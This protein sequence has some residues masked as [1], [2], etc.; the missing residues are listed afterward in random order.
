[1]LVVFLIYLVGGSIID[2]MAFVIL[3]TP[4]FFPAI[5]QMGYD[6]VWA[7]ILLAVTVCVGSVIPPIAM[8]VFVTQKV[9]KVPISV[10]YS[11]VYPFL[12]AM[13]ICILLLFIFPQLVT[14]LPSVLMN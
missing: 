13:M 4:I 10:I 6:P 8:P 3:A 11:G 12:I 5:T 1:M 14:Y 2:D 9:T 7:C